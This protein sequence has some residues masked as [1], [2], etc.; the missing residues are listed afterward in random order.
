MMSDVLDDTT[1]C[2]ATPLHTK[3]IQEPNTQSYSEN[4][5]NCG[6]L[7]NIERDEVANHG[8]I[9]HGNEGCRGDVR[10]RGDVGPEGHRGDVGPKG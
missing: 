8:K 5:I 4:T 2:N 9:N 1:I 7:R 3:C 6:I 10:Y